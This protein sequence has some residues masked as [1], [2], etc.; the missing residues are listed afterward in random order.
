MRPGRRKL[1]IFAKFFRTPPFLVPG[2]GAQGA[3]A[4]QALAG[5][6]REDAGWRGGL[7]NSTRALIFPPE[8]RGVTNIDAWRE[9]VRGAVRGAKSALAG[10]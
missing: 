7:V 1:P 9:S 8:S 5:L 10:V 2:F 6:V 4:D 3:G